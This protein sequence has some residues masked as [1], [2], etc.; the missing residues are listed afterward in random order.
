M[1]VSDSGAAFGALHHSKFTILRTP[2]SLLMKG[3]TSLIS[4]LFLC[5]LLDF[6][7]FNADSELNKIKASDVVGPIEIIDEATGIVETL[8]E[9]QIFP[10]EGTIVTGEEAS[11][12]LYFSNG[13]LLVV[14]AE[15]SL[16]INEFDQK[17]FDSAATYEELRAEPSP[18]SINII[19]NQGIITARTKTLQKN[20][21]FTVT[22]PTMEVA[23]ATATAQISYLVS[24]DEDS[25]QTSVAN[26][27][28]LVKV[29]APETGDQWMPVEEGFLVEIASTDTTGL[30]EVNKD[31]TPTP[32]ASELRTEAI[33]VNQ[34]SDYSSVNISLLGISASPSE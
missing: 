1:M 20:S 31:E 19:L 9:G 28:G 21:S 18:S 13:S 29:K 33:T 26:L 12:I 34:D 23:L 3:I 2:N 16:N 24:E 8:N 11:V 15:T 27:Y 5:P 6:S 7:S 22:S 30:N 25:P 4:V 14:G 32:S 10:A 17:P